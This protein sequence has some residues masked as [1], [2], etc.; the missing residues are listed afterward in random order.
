MTALVH[1]LL[2]LLTACGGP[3]VA[4][5]HLQD[6]AGLPAAVAYGIGFAPVVLLLYGLLSLEDRSAE[7]PRPRGVILGMAGAVSTI[8]INGFALWRL[9]PW[10]GEDVGLVGTGMV[11]GS[12]LSLWM[13]WRAAS[14]V[15]EPET[16]D[17]HRPGP[18]ARDWALLLLNGAFVGAGLLII[19]RSPAIGAGVILFFGTCGAI[20]L[21][22][23]QRKRRTARREAHAPLPDGVA[24]PLSRTP[25]IGAAAAILAAG[26]GTL[27]IGLDAQPV[28]L[29]L[30]A[31]MA[32]SGAVLLVAATSGWL[33]RGSLTLDEE[34]LTVTRRAFA[35]QVPWTAVD[36][37]SIGESFGHEAVFLTLVDPGAVRPEA[38]GHAT[39]VERELRTNGS[40]LGADVVIL[41]VRYGIELRALVAAIE[42]HLG[43]DIPF[44][45]STRAF[46]S[47]TG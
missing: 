10:A 46:G 3:M 38:P 40:W 1:H 6:R 35:Y 29:G 21:G 11:V 47:E 41:P 36:L 20:T 17:V 42:W 19:G 26:A 7:R 14:A 34:G 31:A 28:A 32:L 2:A 24:L 8:A 39:R 27:L 16:P 4:M 15:P 44:Q 25:V 23:I 30:G 13:L 5:G 43:V 22:T 33:P 37:V 12:L 9:D 18:R 45:G